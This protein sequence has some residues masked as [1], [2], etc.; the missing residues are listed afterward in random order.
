MLLHDKLELIAVSGILGCIVFF[1]RY[2][3]FLLG[4]GWVAGDGCFVLWFS[5]VI[6]TSGFR[7][8]K[9]THHHPFLLPG[10]LGYPAF[11][12]WLLALLPEK[13]RERLSS[14]LVP[15]F[16]AF[17]TIL[18]FGMVVWFDKIVIGGEISIW[19]SALFTLLIM[20][21]PALVHSF[22]GP[23][24]FELS[25]RAPS[26]FLFWLGMAGAMLFVNGCKWGIAVFALSM[27]LIANASLFG[28][29]AIVFSFLPSFFISGQYAFLV[30]LPATYICGCLFSFGHH[31][32]ALKSHIAHSRFYLRHW[33]STY[34]G[35]INKWSDFATFPLDLV[36]NPKRAFI[37]VINNTY[38]FGLAINLQLLLL[39]YGLTCNGSLSKISEHPASLFA[40]AWVVGSVI[41]W[42][43]TG[44]TSLRFLGSAF[45][46]LEFS[47]PAQ[48]LLLFQ[49]WYDR[50]WLWI[51]IGLFFSVMFL[52]FFYT[53]IR[54]NKTPGSFTD[55]KKVIAFL[56]QFGPETRIRSLH[57]SEYPALELY[58]NFW[59]LRFPILAD[60]KLIDDNLFEMLY[61]QT[62][63][64]REANPSTIEQVSAQWALD[65][66]IAPKVWLKAALKRDQR[67]SVLEK[68]SVVF[69][70]ASYSVF[71]TKSKD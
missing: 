16:E 10:V 69:E 64:G 54:S 49:L 17:S 59:L 28:L 18:I 40:L 63:T 24:P 23:R 71:D 44:L 66:L 19:Q 55:I 45:R 50:T 33:N 62:P 11:W 53:Y 31:H 13:N 4:Y 29:Q 61:G 20:F 38:L 26:Q 47:L 27:G 25:G 30:W 70:N 46:Y 36:Q 14:F 34:I 1:S 41:A 51:G 58:G 67:Y 6:R 8:P 52:I 22:H 57:D 15:T 32:T 2:L 3:P 60:I 42:L 68:C 39:G 9:G 7:V 5:R 56:S 65:F 48:W 21:S 35:H 43:L 37:T 12:S